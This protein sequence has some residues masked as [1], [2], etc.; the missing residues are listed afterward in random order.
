MRF[1]LFGLLFLFSGLVQ[2]AETLP[3]A[4][5]FAADARQGAAG[6]A[7]ILVFFTSPS[8]PYCREVES[9]YL[10]PMQQRGAY[11]GRLLI[12]TV[13]I[14]SAAPLA[15]FAGRPLTHAEFARRAR[16]R[17]TP[18]I[19]LYGPDGR[20]LVPPL[21]GYSTPDFYSGYLEDSIT[22]AI[23]RLRPLRTARAR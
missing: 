8:C 18:V 15:D 6:A 4:R 16:V 21:F 19:R 14:G 5:D 7:P 9:L 2:A 20:E 17:F 23:A 22:Q 13:E 3:A 10:Q 1:S 11:R 12:R